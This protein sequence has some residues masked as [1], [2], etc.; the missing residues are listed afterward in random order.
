MRC[1]RC[2][3]VENGQ[4]G[5]GQYYCWHCTLEFHGRPGQWRFYSVDLEGGLVELNAG[6]PAAVGATTV[7]ELEAAI[8]R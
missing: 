3:K 1:P 6:E 2:D 8:A 4:V 5:N 7:P